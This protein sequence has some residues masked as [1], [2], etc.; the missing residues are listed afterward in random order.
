MQYW[1]K[2]RVSIYGNIKATIIPVTVKN[3]KL[4]L[5]VG[6]GSGSIAEPGDSSH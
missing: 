2:G 4:K 1:L 6:M 5:T 3:Y